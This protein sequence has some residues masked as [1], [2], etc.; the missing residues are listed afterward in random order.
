[1]FVDVF[2]DLIFDL[3]FVLF[4]D[5][6]ELD[7]DRDE[8]IEL[9][10]DLDWFKFVVVFWF[11]MLFWDIEVLFDIELKW[12]CNLLFF[13]LLVL[14]MFLDCCFCVDWIVFWE[15]W[16]D[17][18]DWVFEFNFVVILVCNF[19]SFCCCWWIWLIICFNIW[20]FFC[21]FWILE[22]KFLMSCVI[23]WLVGNWLFLFL[24]MICKKFF[25]FL[26][27]LNVKL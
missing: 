10:V 9:F 17:F 12:L 21:I 20:C 15:F 1:M 7:L 27:F 5:V 2:F 11:V 3:L 18:K 23:F 26:S 19:L 24:I 14:V 8:F 22:C 25:F 4:L 13:N 6:I 16:I